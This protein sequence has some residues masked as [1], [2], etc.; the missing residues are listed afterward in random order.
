[1]QRVLSAEQDPTRKPLTEVYIVISL[2]EKK[3]ILDPAGSECLDGLVD[4]W[5]GVLSL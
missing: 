5:C 1:M 3:C 4:E 2:H